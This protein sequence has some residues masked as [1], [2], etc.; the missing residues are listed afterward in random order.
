MSEELKEGTWVKSIENTLSGY[1]PR[2]YVYK[3]GKIVDVKRI[4]TATGNAVE[5][6]YKA[7]ETESMNYEVGRGFSGYNKQGRIPLETMASKVIEDAE[8]VKSLQT[9]M[10]KVKSEIERGKDNMH[11]A[12]DKSYK[13][14]LADN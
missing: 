10:N 1:A 4:K 11:E 13:A 8:E 5:E 9:A 3:L 6:T 12:L 14:A 2:L 7:Y